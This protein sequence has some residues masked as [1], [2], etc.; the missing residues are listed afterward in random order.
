[1]LCGVDG[2]K[3]IVRSEP[4]GMARIARQRRLA[5]ELPVGR[6]WITWPSSRKH[7]AGRRAST[8]IASG[9]PRVMEHLQEVD[10]RQPMDIEPR[11]P[12]SQSTACRIAWSSSLG[13]NGLHSTPHGAA[14]DRALVVARGWA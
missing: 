12:V 3:T 5:D 14:L 6:P 10:Q 7:V 2:G 9:A 1:M 13:V 8:A 4:A 11:N